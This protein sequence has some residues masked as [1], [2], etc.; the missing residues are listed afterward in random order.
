LSE[1]TSYVPSPLDSTPLNPWTGWSA[2]GGMIPLIGV[3]PINE[4]DGSLAG[5][6]VAAGSEAKP[7]RVAWP[8]PSRPAAEAPEGAT[9]A[10]AT[11]AAMAATRRKG[12]LMA[13][14]ARECA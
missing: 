4:P 12:F 14:H 6:N 2:K 11:A 3:V 1:R 5:T 13:R 10:S 8:K 7:V 9:A